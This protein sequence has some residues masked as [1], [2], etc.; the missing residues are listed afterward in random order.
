MIKSLL[1][2]LARSLFILVFEA[3]VAKA[4][5]GSRGV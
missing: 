1:A 5:P 3:A 2:G 4:I